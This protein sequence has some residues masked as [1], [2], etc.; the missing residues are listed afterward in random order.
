[1]KYKFCYQLQII[2]HFKK[3]SNLEKQ[4]TIICVVKKAVETCYKDLVSIKSY[5]TPATIIRPIGTLFIRLLSFLDIPLVIASLI[6]GAASLEDIK[7]LGS[8]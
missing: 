4:K 2:K 7:K 6:I 3:L 5:E 1:M 8:N